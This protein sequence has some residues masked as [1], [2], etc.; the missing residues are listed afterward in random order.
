LVPLL[1]AAMYLAFYGLVEHPFHITP[2]PRFVFWTRQHR[3]ALDH[4]L[5]GVQN[6]KGFIQLTG[7]VG[8][9][10]TTLCRA[11]L[12]RLGEAVDT[13]LILNPFLSA[14]Q[15]VRAILHDFGLSTEGADT[16]AC[17]EALN[18][19]LLERNQAGRNVV[20]FIDEAQNLP[21]P[22]L[23]QVRLLSNLETDNTKLMQV[24][25]CGQPE[26]RERLARPELRQLRQRIAVRY[27]LGP[28]DEQDMVRY[29]GHRLAVAA[30]GRPPAIDF[31]E[32][33]LWLIYAY[34]KGCPRLVN[35]LMDNVLL[36]GYVEQCHA[37][38]E[39][40]VRRAVA[41]LEGEDG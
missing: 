37:I 22:A 19:F 7:E 24:V 29:I 16:L 4:L 36:A 38:N 28:L 10:K 35:T 39:H 31:S 41:Q 20:L 3:E 40:C 1:I 2:D 32:A 15:L 27:Q 8:T 14:D 23:E 30:D 21:M 25:L 6:R 12:E 9:G 11:C 5:Y 13:A 34:S 26:V 17:V 33:A 18:R